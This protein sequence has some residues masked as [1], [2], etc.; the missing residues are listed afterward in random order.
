MRRTDSVRIGLI[1]A[2]CCALLFA[3]YGGFELLVRSHEGSNQSKFIAS[4]ACFGFLFGAILAFHPLP[5]EKG[6]D[7]PVLRTILGSLSGLCLG[8]L[9]QWSFEGVVLSTLVSA[10]LGYAGTAWARHI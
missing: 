6:I 2:V 10:G 9:W 3:A 8:L 7:R 1:V 4:F 5:G